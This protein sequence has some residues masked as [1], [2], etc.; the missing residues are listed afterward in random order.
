MA[1]QIFTA[2]TIT[3]RREI[4]VKVSKGMS[5]EDYRHD[6]YSVAFALWGKGARLIGD[7]R[8]VKKI[9]DS[10]SEAACS[11]GWGWVNLRCLSRAP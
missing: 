7:R 5:P 2:D 3:G 4:A 11:K 9:G 1:Y 10:F 6:A 8:T